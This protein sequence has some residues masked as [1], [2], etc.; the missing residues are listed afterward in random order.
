VVPLDVYDLSLVPEIKPVLYDGRRPPFRPGTFDCGIALFVLHHIPAC[1]TKL[2]NLLS[3]ARRWIIAEDLYESPLRSRVTAAM[4]HLLNLF[5][6]EQHGLGR[7][8]SQWKEIFSKQ[9]WQVLQT[10]RH[11]SEFWFNPLVQQATYILEP[12]D[13]G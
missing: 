1:E 2:S 5:S 13:I 8:D 11:G 3:L 7:S 10:V 12:M 4:D 6:S 9:G